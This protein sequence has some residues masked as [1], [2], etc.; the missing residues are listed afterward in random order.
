MRTVVATALALLVTAA[1]NAPQ[2]PH[3]YSQYLAHMPSSILVLPPTNESVEPLAS[4]NYLSVATA[5]IAEHGYYVF[6]VAVVDSM[7]KENGLPTPA[8][9]RTAELSKLHEIIG[10]DAVLYLHVHDWGTSYQVLNS[11][12][13]VSVSGRLVDAQTGTLL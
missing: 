9:M 13:I 10:A 6:P 7:L 2:K 4:Y 11:Q 3:D 5:P 1:C 8:E 12:T